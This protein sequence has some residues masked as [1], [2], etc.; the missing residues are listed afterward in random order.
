M[1]GPKRE[2]RNLYD[3]D[4]SKLVRA[5]YSWRGSPL[6]CPICRDTRLGW[7][8]LS[9]NIECNDCGVV[10]DERELYDATHGGPV[11]DAVL[12]GILQKRADWM[13]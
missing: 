7:N 3:L 11:N 13:R 8:I 5:S 9:S 2:R 12:D 6:Y 1:A 10:F 4:K